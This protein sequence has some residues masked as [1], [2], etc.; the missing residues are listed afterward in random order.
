MS[1]VREL[2]AWITVGILLASFAVALPGGLP[3][4]L[5]TA[6]GGSGAGALAGTSVPR[7]GFFTT[8]PT[9]PVRANDLL[10]SSGFCDNVSND[11]S[12]NLTSLGTLAVAYTVYLNATPCSADAP[13]GQT[14][15]AVVT[16]SDLGAS[17]STPTYLGDANCAGTSPT[18]YPDAWEPALTSLA[19]GTLVLAYVEF[20]V[21]AGTIVPSVS[22]G[23]Y[24]WNVPADRLVV[25]ELYPGGASWTSPVVVASATNPLLTNSSFSPVRP[26]ITATGSTV[27]LAWMG[28]AEEMA[29]AF[30]PSYTYIQAGVALM[31]SELAVSTTG[32]TSFGSPITLPGE[33]SG[34]NNATLNP[35]VLVSP[36]GTLWVSYATDLTFLPEAVCLGSSENCAL[37]GTWSAD[38]WV[39]ASTT[40][41]SSFTR[42]VAA[43]GVLAV[44]GYT[45]GP[46]ID[47]APVLAYSSSTSELA[48]S[49]D[50]SAASTVGCGPYGC[51]PVA[52]ERAVMVENSS[53]GGANW[54]GLHT[55]HPELLQA[56]GYPEF[57]TN[58]TYE[59]AIAYDAGGTLHLTMS[60]LNITD[61]A[62]GASGYGCRESQLYAT[63]TDNGATFGPLSTLTANST[64]TDGPL[65]LYA[66]APQGEYASMLIV[67]SHL[68]TAWT[69]TECPGYAGLGSCTFPDSNSL[70]S[71]ELSSLSSGPVNVTFTETGLPSGTSWGASVLGVS[72][73]GSTSSL[74]VGGIPV[75]D[76]ATF[77]VSPIVP[78]A[79]GTQYAAGPLSVVG[80]MNLTGNQTITVAFSLQYEVDVAT[81]PNLPAPRI[82]TYCL[83]N[84]PFTFESPGCPS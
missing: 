44:S 66:T 41:G 20:N 64:W 1:R 24:S 65:Y 6:T 58:Q 35:T 34:A 32:G 63:S 9:P 25:T 47:P 4:H 84:V 12:M 77:W 30:S 48:L 16:S 15:V 80:P 54:S 69:S 70:T 55:V 81:V 49:F 7:G 26:S 79:W 62:P 50:A 82:V 40:N 71:V 53:N 27:Y 14:L 18:G 43:T 17:W 76:N 28:Y 21:T 42:S 68:L 31:D 23:P 78:V 5:G 52:A 75:G 38:L 57:E 37:G 13:Y 33:L 60:F 56:I 61:C 73:W 72:T 2:V 11:P 83:D 59:P 22:F 45:I 19:N 51:A 67:G 10:C 46:W 39:D 29:T 36:S 74:V 8:M 3:S